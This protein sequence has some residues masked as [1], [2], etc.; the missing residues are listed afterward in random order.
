MGLP[1]ILQRAGYKWGYQSFYRG[2]VI[3]GVTSHSTEGRLLVRLP[4]IL[5]RGQIGGSVIWGDALHQLILSVILQSRG[6]VISEV[7][8]QRIGY[9]L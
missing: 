6:Q 5:Q 3:S 8:L 9:N 7:I 1:V 4:V 2:L